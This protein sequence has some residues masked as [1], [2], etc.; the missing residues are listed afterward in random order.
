MNADPALLPIITSRT[1]AT[2]LA[3]LSLHPDHR[4]QAAV[5]AHP[6]TSPFILQRL[7]PSFPAQVLTNPALPLLRL[8]HP[9]LFHDWSPQALLALV[10]QPDAPA[11][12]LHLAAQR[13]EPELPAA[14]ARHPALTSAEVEGLSAHP[15]WLVRARIAARPD[16]S[17]RLRE[18][19]RTDPDYGV[20]LAI[21][22]RTDLADAD[23]HVLLND[24]SRLIRQV[25]AQTAHTMN[26]TVS[27]PGRPEAE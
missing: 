8:A 10:G 2:E 1:P 18:R 5:A 24:P 27:R 4:V 6:N 22:S 7:A 13:P 12:L 14:V 19:L 11:W 23:L 20:R 3:N 25:A 15:A 26:S 21:A 9:R 16:L 17:A